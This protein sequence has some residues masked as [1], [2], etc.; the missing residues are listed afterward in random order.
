MYAKVY[1]EIPKLKDEFDT[2][3]LLQTWQELC[4]VPDWD[5]DKVWLHGDLL[6]G[7]ILVQQ[8]RLA[9]VL[10]FS[11]LGIGDPACDCIIA[12]ALF[13]KDSREVFKR[14]LC[15]I[16]ANTWLRGKGWALFIAAIMLPY[17]CDKSPMFAKLARRILC[18]MLF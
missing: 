3:L 6:P 4:A 17:Y 5:K 7:N 9:A 16:D 8:Q 18:N 2:D 14:H 11:D 12:W 10:D 1:A 13:N 15:G